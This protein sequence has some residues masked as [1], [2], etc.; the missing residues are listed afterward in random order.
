VFLPQVDV[1]ER[2]NEVVIVVEIPGVERTDVRISWKD[3][4]LTIAGHKRQRPEGGIARYMC[5]ERS[6]GPFRREIAI[7][8]PIDHKSARAELRNGL[9]K[10]YLPK[11]G[12]E[13]HQDTIPID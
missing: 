9:M 10:I 4:I 3:N 7:G 6:Y 8:I 5:V 2:A 11:I 12:E 13:R 1:C